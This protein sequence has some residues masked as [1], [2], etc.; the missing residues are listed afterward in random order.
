MSAERISI[1]NRADR[2]GDAT[3]ALVKQQSASTWTRGLVIIQGTSRSAGLYPGYPGVEMPCRRP[4]LVISLSLLALSVDTLSQQARSQGLP[5]DEAK[6]S[7]DLDSIASYDRSTGSAGENHAIDYLDAELKKSGIST[8]IYPFSALVSFPLRASLTVDGQSAGEAL[9]YSFSGNTPSQ[10]VAGRLYVADF[11][12]VPGQPDELVLPATC[13]GSIVLVDSWPFAGV[14]RQIERCGALAAV[15]TSQTK[16]LVNFIASPVWGTPAASNIETLPHL[17][18]VTLR[19]AGFLAL[20]SRARASPTQARLVAE[21]SRERRTLRLLVAT[22]VGETPQFVLMGAHIDAWQSGA[23]D[24]GVADTMM[25]SFARAI[26]AGP[27]PHRTVLFAWWPGH[28]QGRYAGSAWFADAQWERLNEYGVAYLN[29]DV[30]GSRD[31]THYSVDATAELSLLA[32]R[33]LYQSVGL[34]PEIAPPS[35]SAD[36]SFLG[37]GLP[38]MYIVHAGEHGPSDWWHDASDTLDKVSVPIVGEEYRVVSAALMSLVQSSQLPLRF[39]PLARQ[40]E[41]RLRLLQQEAGNRFSLSPALTAAAAFEGEAQR[42]DKLLESGGHLFDDASFI[43][44][45]RILNPILYTTGDRFVPDEA[46]DLPLIPSLAGVSRLSAL[47]TEESEL[48]RVD[49]VRGQNRVVDALERA[50]AALYALDH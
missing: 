44:V 2:R 29:E 11:K 10:G 47:N 25:L 24:N 15:F 36:Q 46:V 20:A 32:T 48:A 19:R 33:S 28:S 41:S 14:S 5:F 13:H 23:T 45:P 43:R 7:R 21:A 9:T 26:R 39:A 37:I 6:F 1:L 49:L 34:R 8:T 50:R 35:R 31:A 16:G 4:Y 42:I 12:P 22:I 17:P 40:I 3:T 38:S 18:G 30:L 27:K